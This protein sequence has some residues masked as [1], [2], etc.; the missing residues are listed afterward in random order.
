MIFRFMVGSTGTAGPTVTGGE[1]GSP[2]RDHLVRDRLVP[3]TP[4]RA[5]GHH[6]HRQA[7]VDGCVSRSPTSLPCSCCRA[8]R[9]STPPRT[10]P[11]R[12][13]A[14]PGRP[15]PSPPHLRRLRPPRPR[16]SRAAGRSWPGS[17]RHRLLRSAHGSGGA[18][19]G[20]RTGRAEACR[21]R[22]RR[23]RPTRARPLRPHRVIRGG[24][25]RARPASRP[26][27][28]CGRYAAPPGTSPRA[29]RGCAAGS[30]SSRRRGR[31]RG[32]ARALWP[33]HRWAIRLC[34]ARCARR[35]GNRPPRRMSRA[36][37][38]RCPAYGS[39]S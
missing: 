31:G 25:Y 4:G 15:Y 35:L 22:G 37:R 17:G 2:G 28:A 18:R 27:A 21:P 23:A 38:W 30:P 5:A 32:A 24:G 7:T 34:G 20:R 39:R 29:W 33:C 1:G 36:A 11:R 12:S 9:P 26:G 6:R 3:V 19:P 8:A 14:L 13:T 10:A 16:R